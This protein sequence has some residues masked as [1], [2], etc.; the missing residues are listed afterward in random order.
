LVSLESPKEASSGN[1]Y[2]SS[3]SRRVDEPKSP[4]LGYWGAWMCVS[5]RQY[6]SLVPT[7]AVY[8]P[9]NPGKK[10]SFLSSLARTTFTF[11]GE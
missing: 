8:E 5:V 9:I 2:V 7:E 4:V 1:V 11:S 6:A 3:Q 10:N